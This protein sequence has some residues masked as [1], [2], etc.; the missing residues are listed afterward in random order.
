MKKSFKL[1]IFMFLLFVCNGC[2][3]IN[4]KY[5]ITYYY[6]DEI[7]YQYNESVGEVV[8]NKIVNKEGY[9][10]KGWDIDNDGIC[11]ELP[12]VN[13]NIN[14]FAILEEDADYLN[15]E[16]F[17]NG[18]LYETKR[19][20]KGTEIVFPTLSDY[21][22]EKYN[23]YFDGWIN[24]EGDKLNNYIINDDIKIYASF[25]KEIRLYKYKIYSNNE[26]IIE[27]E[28]EYQTKIEYPSLDYIM[29]DDKIAIFTHWLYNGEYK[30]FIDTIEEDLVITADY[31]SQ[32]VVV[33]NYN[34]SM[35]IQKVE[36]YNNINFDSFDLPEG[37][38]INWYL[39]PDYQKLYSRSILTSDYLSL[40]GKL[41]KIEELDDH[42]LKL[43]IEESNVYSKDELLDVF[44]VMLLNKISEKEI[45]ICFEYD[46]LE[47][48]MNYLSSNCILLR[49]YKFSASLINNSLKIKIEFD[50]ENFKTSSNIY[51]SELKSLNT[52]TS[53]NINSNLYIDNVTKTYEVIDSDSLFYVLQYGYKPVIK[54]AKLN[55]LYNKMRTILLTILE[56]ELTDLQKALRIYEWVITN[57]VYDK[58]T[59]YRVTD[60]PKEYSSFFLEGVFND[61]LAV[62]DG[63][64]KA[65]SALC[66][67]AGIKC[68]QTTGV[69]KDSLINHAWN[70]MLID[71]KWYIVDPTSGG[72]IV[73]DLEIVSYYFF[74]ISEKDYENYYINDNKQF[75]NL[76]TDNT[77]NA[78]NDLYILEE[79]TKIKINC[80]NDDDII[81]LMKLFDNCQDNNICMEIYINIDIDNFDEK[82]Q[83]LF[84]KARITSK[85][86]YITFNKD[87]HYIINLMK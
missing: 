64:S 4:N 8:K 67:M 40:Y 26:L 87:G 37:Y 76:K 71:G 34:N 43:D 6:G 25:T 68:V 56:P 78:Y 12:V 59:L 69:S 5:L 35:F 2:E 66:N 38:R 72:T 65:F 42:I 30:D 57:C 49:N 9:I 55:E 82:I 13:G 17:N 63:I 46:S 31:S 52:I 16:F 53:Q 74:M 10:F 28:V 39:D 23:Y 83:E 86:T 14:L 45:N 51:Y 81:K 80:T 22:D 7:I 1:V 3:L 44:N 75:S 24:E 84:F 15:C 70:K 18:S 79:D 77:Y 32:N 36:K 21:Q 48:L 60:T 20:K 50:K 61:N 62:C 19:Y 47:N 29:K 27:K 41:E 54:D 11:D 85:F 58:E 33:L 73:G